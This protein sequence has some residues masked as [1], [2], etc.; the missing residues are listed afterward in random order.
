[1]LSINLNYILRGLI[2]KVS[3][4]FSDYLRYFHKIEMGRIKIGEKV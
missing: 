2:S 4:K 3:L 1:M